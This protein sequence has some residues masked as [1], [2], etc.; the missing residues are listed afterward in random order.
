MK[1]PTRKNKF[2]VKD[3]YGTRW[4]VTTRGKVNPTNWKL[5]ALLESTFKPKDKKK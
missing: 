1:K 5:Q 3:E 4:W 2:I